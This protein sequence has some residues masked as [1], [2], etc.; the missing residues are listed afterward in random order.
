MFEGERTSPSMRV[1][2][3]EDRIVGITCRL[4]S[5]RLLAGCGVPFRMDVT[6]SDIEC[7]WVVSPWRHSLGNIS[8]LTYRA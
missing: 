2:Y 6:L 5:E 4:Y 3:G 8:Y 1:G 7:A